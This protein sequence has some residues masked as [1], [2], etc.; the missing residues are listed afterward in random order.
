MSEEL[1]TAARYRQHAEDL[2][3]IAAHKTAINNRETLRKLAANY[4]HMADT[5]EA[6]DETNKARERS[7]A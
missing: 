5:M 3:T 7:K 1:R 2:R 6:I 4:E